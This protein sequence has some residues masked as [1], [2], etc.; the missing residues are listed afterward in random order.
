MMGKFEE[1]NAEMNGNEQR[2]SWSAWETKVTHGL[3]KGKRDLKS[4]GPRMSLM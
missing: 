4:K 3:V 1:S 2:V